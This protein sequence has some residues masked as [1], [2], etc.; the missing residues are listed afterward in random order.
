MSHLVNVCFGVKQVWDEANGGKQVWVTF[1]E[2]NGGKQV[3]VHSFGKCVN[4]FESHIIGCTTT[5]FKTTIERFLHECHYS[6]GLHSQLP[7]KGLI[8][9]YCKIRKVNNGN[10]KVWVRLTGPTAV[11]QNHNWRFPACKGVPLNG[12]WQLVGSIQTQASADQWPLT[13]RAL[14]YM[15]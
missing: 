5:Q 13:T 7:C 10:Q 14:L 12:K 8:D 15:V 1:C 3:R 6:C 11:L 4:R 9:S 2:A